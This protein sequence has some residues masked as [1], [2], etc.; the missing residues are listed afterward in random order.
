MT[1]TVAE[2]GQAGV[3]PGSQHQRLRQAQS[4]AEA[5]SRRPVCQASGRHRHDLGRAGGAQVTVQI[6]RRRRQRAGRL[7]G[8]IEVA[9]CNESES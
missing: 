5:R 2:A 1:W 3:A 9:E 4:D 8:V 6:G 7:T